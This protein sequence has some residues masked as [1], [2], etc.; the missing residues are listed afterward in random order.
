MAVTAQQN[1]RLGPMARI[2]RNNRR[3]KALISLPLGRLAGRDGGDE[4]A[5]AI[6]HDDGLKAIFVMMGIEQ[7]QLLA[8]MH[9]VKC[10]I[11]VEDNPLGN[12]RKTRNKDRP[13]PG[14][15]PARRGYQADFPAARSWTANTIAADGVR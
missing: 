10:I 14:P 2:A 4:A 1:L 5:P 9:G 12:V 8:P 3:R 15:C 7:A 6:E 13:W 11:N